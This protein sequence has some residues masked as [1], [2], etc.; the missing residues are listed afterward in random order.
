MDEK[1]LVQR[2]KDGNKNSLN[3]L[4]QL[5]YKMIFGF[6]IKMTTNESLAQD[7]TQE[8][9]LKAVLNIKK[10]N[11]DCKFST[12]LIKI[13][14][15]L[16][17]DYMKKNK[18]IEFRQDVISIECCENMEEKV[19]ISLQ[20]TEAIEQLRK[21]SYNKRT[22]F[23]LKHYYGYSLE[24]ISKI[25]D[26]PQGTVKSRISNCISSLRKVLKEVI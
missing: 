26:C 11:C 3:I 25:M 24:E 20:Y 23:I 22:S 16:Y 2:A 19:M 13:S 17:K 4:F 21:M 12:W 15:N 14:I 10:F 18:N 8:T 1:E 7:I 5:N 6:V 9:F